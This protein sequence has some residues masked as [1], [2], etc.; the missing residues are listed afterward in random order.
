MKTRQKHTIPP[1]VI[2]S[3][4]G[5]AR[6]GGYLALGHQGGI[7]I[8]ALAYYCT[9]YRLIDTLSVSL[10]CLGP[11][12]KATTVESCSGKT[13]FKSL[14]NR[15]YCQ[16]EE[17]ASDMLQT[18]RPCAEPPAMYN[19]MPHHSRDH[20]SIARGEVQRFFVLVFLMCLGC[21]VCPCC[22]CCPYPEFRGLPQNHDF[23]CLHWVHIMHVR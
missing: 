15:C 2:L 5:I 8:L 9:D 22:P 11:R 16:S 13:T 3:R 1:A 4:K 23:S 7:W 12:P 20:R 17:S 19:M 18:T 14:H 10:V 6:C 21:S